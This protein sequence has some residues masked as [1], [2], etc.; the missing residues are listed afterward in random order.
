MKFT[1][2]IF[3]IIGCIIGLAILILLIIK[4]N[5]NS[6]LVADFIEIHEN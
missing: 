3:L 4:K 5:E 6:E 2:N 1:K